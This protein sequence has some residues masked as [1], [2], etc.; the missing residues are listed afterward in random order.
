MNV[1]PHEYAR[2][3]PI[4]IRRHARTWPKQFTVSSQHS[5]DVLPAHISKPF[6]TCLM[7]F[8]VSSKPWKL[9]ARRTP[10]AEIVGG[11]GKE[12]SP[13]FLARLAERIPISLRVD[14]GTLGRAHARLLPN[15]PPQASRFRKINLADFP[16]GARPPTHGDVNHLMRAGLGQ[17]DSGPKYLGQE[18]ALW[19]ALSIIIVHPFCD[20]NGRVA[21]S[22]ACRLDSIAGRESR[23][24]ISIPYLMQCGTVLYNHAIPLAVVSNSLE[25]ILD[26]FKRAQLSL[27][28]LTDAVLALAA[29]YQNE[30]RYFSERTGSAAFRYLCS[31]LY[32]SD[33]NFNRA[34][35]RMT[36]SERTIVDG[37][38]A[39][40]VNERGVLWIN[41]AVTKRV[42]RI[43]NLIFKAF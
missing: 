12:S 16:S 3:L 34:L 8:G 24:P 25:P 43:S 17:N 23:V 33:D 30:T 21:R 10:S 7:P 4:F 6:V 39:V 2:R 41:N 28:N 18:N 1:D 22:V 37:V 29:E 13:T 40:H 20:G 32:V 9:G 26:V 19:T 14:E 11:I 36:K 42:D 27:R 38:Y 31:S 35:R 5:K 15:A